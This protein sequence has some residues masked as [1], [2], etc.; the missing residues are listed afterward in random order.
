MIEYSLT[1]ISTILFLIFMLATIALIVFLFIFWV[2]MI[3]D[4]A[5]KKFKND[6]DK[7]VWIL[8]VI[9]LNWIGA[10]IYYFVIKKRGK[11]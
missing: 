11:R 8:I 4:I 10:I 3:I 5:K 6:N 7:I 1:L 2:L 9:F